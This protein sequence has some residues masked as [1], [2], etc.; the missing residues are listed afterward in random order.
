MQSWIH[1]SDLVQ[2]FYFA[3]QNQ[4]EGVYNAVAPNPITNK[5]LTKAIARVLNKPLFMPAV[6]KFAMQI[7]LGEMHQLLFTSQHVS[8]QKIKDKQFYF[9]FNDVEA[10][11]ADLLIKP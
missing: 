11:L 6:P 9:R 4:L 1:I 10:A 5:D 8:S 3:V 7:F 2:L